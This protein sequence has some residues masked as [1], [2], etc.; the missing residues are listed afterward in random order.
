MS[1]R[2]TFFLGTQNRCLQNILIVLEWAKRTTYGK[3]AIYHC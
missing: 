1:L 3:D 2:N